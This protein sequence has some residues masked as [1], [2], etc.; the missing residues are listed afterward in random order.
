MPLIDHPAGRDTALYPVFE[1]LKLSRYRVVKDVLAETGHNWQLRT[2]RSQVIALYAAHTRAIDYWHQEEP[3]NPDALM[4][5]ARVLTQRMFDL[6]LPANDP[7]VINAAN[8]A[9]RACHAAIRVCQQCPVAWISLLALAQFDADPRYKQ[10]ADH[11]T[12]S[13]TTEAALPEGPWPLFW[14][15]RQRDPEN[16]EA[17]QRMLQFF[18]ARGTGA[19]VF[20]QWTAMRAGECSILLMTPLYAYAEDFRQRRISQ[21]TS[22][23]SYWADHRVRHYVQQARDGWFRFLD[24]D[25]RS[26]PALSMDLNL[27]AYAL[28]VSG[29]GGAGPAFQAIG[30]YAT[31]MPWQTLGSRSHWEENF[32]KARDFALAREP[33]SR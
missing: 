29:V 18:Y 21:Q 10:D 1:D 25:T 15:V 30:R 23:F 31:A 2:Y 22:D 14:A 6:R 26:S 27:L 13:Q 17:Y 9:R 5:W 12:P 4:M 24:A 16:R 20:A 33:V 19:H 32:R 11:W 28:G 7:M 3:N 8:H